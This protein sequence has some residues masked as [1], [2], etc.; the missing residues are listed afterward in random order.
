[1]YLWLSL[2]RTPEAL[3][4]YH[5]APWAMLVLLE[6]SLSP[7]TVHGAAVEPLRMLQSMKETRN[8]ERLK[9]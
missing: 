3:A 8:K 4:G 5:Q 7:W 6:A 1:M 9:E 2:V